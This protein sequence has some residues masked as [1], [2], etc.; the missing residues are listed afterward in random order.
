MPDRSPP[1]ALRDVIAIKHGFAFSS[2]YFV[3]EGEYVLLTPGNFREEGGFRWLGE[4]QRFYSGPLPDNFVLSG[5]EM[6]IAMTEQAPGLLGSTFF[7]PEDRTYLHNQRLGLIEIT[8][9]NRVDAGYLHY[10]FASTDVRRAI[11]AD[12]TGTK[13][14]HTSPGKILSLEA[15]LRPLP[16][17]RKIAEILGTWDRAIELC[18]QRVALFKATLLAFQLHIF[19]SG[20]RSQKQLRPA[21][22]VF[23]SVSERNRPDLPLLAVMQDL[24]IVRRDGLD[25]RVMM[26][27]GDTENYKVVR[28]GD[29]V[30]SLRSFEG[31]IELSAVEGLVSPAYTVLRSSTPICSNYYRHF[32][33]SRSFIGRLDKLIFGIRDGKQIAFRDFGDMKIP[34]PSEAD[35]QQYGDFLDLAERQLRIARDEI[36][37]FQ[38]QKRGLIQKLLTGEWRVNAKAEAAA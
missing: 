31:G 20:Y 34:N 38:K 6:L 11:F 3:D 5:G 1:C 9:P 22:D 16:E 17:Q 18:E 28:Q 37:A 24:G 25:R 33:K 8:D 7:V 19:E 2:D 35:Q 21:K 30:I 29:F 26:P 27:D 36:G 10:F 4:K 23:H 13:V 15:N 32:F 14:K 12:A